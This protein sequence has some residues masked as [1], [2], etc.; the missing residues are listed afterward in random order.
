MAA[1]SIATTRLVGALMLFTAPAL[2]TAQVKINLLAPSAEVGGY[3]AASGWDS[4]HGTKRLILPLLN[5]TFV[6]N[7]GFLPPSKDLVDRELPAS[8][9]LT[10]LQPADFKKIADA[11]HDSLVAGLKAQGVEVMSYDP[12]S[13]NPGYQDLAHR[14]PRTGREQALPVIYQDIGN[15]SGARQGLTFVAYGFPWIESF[16]LENYLPATRLT[17]ELD[18]T[19]PIISFLVD[20]VGYS[21]DRITT[22]DWS[23]F[24]TGAPAGP[25]PALRAFPQIYLA[26][27]SATL[28]TAEGQTAT[29][30]LT[31][32]IGYERPFVNRIVPARG[33]SKLERRGGSYDV[34][35][36]PA[37]YRQAVI[38]ALKPQVELIARKLA[39]GM[40]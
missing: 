11:V 37:A 16:M 26:A 29:L 6:T 38:D 1:I 19:L 23:K 14:A 36:D 10:G 8:L 12:M 40:Q 4:L 2:L 30:T 33:R 25:V 20:F 5:L 39:A 17:R 15:V 31:T 13:V 24:T 35:V 32:P 21:T 28:L 9:R 18:A 22:F 27:G 34:E 7:S 3:Y